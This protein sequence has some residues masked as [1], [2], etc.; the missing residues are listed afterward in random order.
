RQDDAIFTGFETELNYKISKHLVFRQ[1]SDF[2]QSINLNTGVAIPFTPQPTFKNS[3]QWKLSKTKFIKNPI[4]EFE[5]QYYFPAKGKLRIDRSE[6]ETPSAFLFNVNSKF[7][8]F[9]NQQ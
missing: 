7:E 1:T 8:L 2:V 9:M 4:I 3:I 6:R 5:Q